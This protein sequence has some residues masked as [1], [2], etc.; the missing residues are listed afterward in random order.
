MKTL[1]K[2]LDCH[3]DDFRRLYEVERLTTYE[4]AARYNTNRYLVA[5]ILKRHGVAMRTTY[6]SRFGIERDERAPSK[7]QLEK[8]LQDGLQYHEIADLYG[9][10]KT[11]VTYWLQRYNIQWDCTN[12]TQ[13]HKRRGFI[14]PTPQEL[15]VMYCVDLLST[16]EI[17]RKLNCSKRLIADRLTRYGIEL[18]D[19]GWSGK[20]FKCRDGNLVKSTYEE[21]VANW[22]HDHQIPYEYEPQLPFDRTRKSDFLAC[23][24]YIEIWGVRDNQTYESR[25]EIKIE[26]YRLHNLPLVELGYWQFSAQKKDA[27]RKH[28]AKAFISH[29]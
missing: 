4:I 10:D 5:S 17:G 3:I 11:A 9:C 16:D 6:N 28:L 13:R 21:R 29:P 12:W 15:F 26:Q 24:K 23:G 27:W 22:L 2:S 20:L 19:P 7:E 18:R 14:E 25:K 1:R 8:H